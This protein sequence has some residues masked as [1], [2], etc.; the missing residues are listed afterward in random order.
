[1][2]KPDQSSLAGQTGEPT[3]PE[4]P[5]RVRRA[6][7]C[8]LPAL[9]L[10]ERTCFAIPWSEQSLKSDLASATAHLWVAEQAG[11][12]VG[13]IACYQGGDI[14]QINNLAVLPEARR[15][16][17]GRLLI[18]ALLNWAS[19]AGITAVDLE[20][21][22]SNQAARSLYEACGFEV[23]GRRPRYYADNGEDANIMLKKISENT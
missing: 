17:T 14:A 7:N 21:R 22:P 23:V 19:T 6:E 1:M 16:G 9:V 18:E 11:Q 2:I 5:I 13:Y 20:V 8:D 15:Q 10:I 4:L 3:A 12:V